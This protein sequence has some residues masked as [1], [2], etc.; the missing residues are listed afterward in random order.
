[1]V[2]RARAGVAAVAVAL[3]CGAACITHDGGPVYPL[4]PSPR[5]GRDRVALLLG[6]VATVDGAQVPANQ[7]TFELLPRCHVVSTQTK[8]L[9]FDGSS[10]PN[11]QGEVTGTLPE[12]F[13]AIDMKAG[14][15]Y[16]IER[17]VQAIGG[18]SANVELTARDVAPDG[19]S[20]NLAP[21]HTVAEL[22]AC[23]RAPP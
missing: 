15:T 22:V 9:A 3:C 16:A 14:H 13:Y 20:A 8:L 23:K 7:S 18:D 2:R 12:L 21:A 10:M 19:Q 6:P 17:K 1:L 4:Y 5:L 11:P